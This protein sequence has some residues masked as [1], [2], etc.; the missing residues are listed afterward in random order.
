MDL[1]RGHGLALE[2]MQVRLDLNFDRLRHSQRTGLNDP[3][4]VLLPLEFCSLLCGSLVGNT[5]PVK[6][7]IGYDPESLSQKS[8]CM[9]TRPSCPTLHLL[10]QRVLLYIMSHV[11]V[12]F[13]KVIL[14][15]SAPYRIILGTSNLNVKW[16]HPHRT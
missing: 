15:D 10:V 1:Q 16:A 11:S 4:S 6:N 2:H 5:S 7:T 13:R 9:T 14:L 3:S 8:L 12:Q